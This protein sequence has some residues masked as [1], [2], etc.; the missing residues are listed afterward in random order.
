M[1]TDITLITSL[2]HTVEFLPDYLAFAQKLLSNATSANLQLQLVI[3]ANDATTE[4]QTLLT[5]F[6]SQHDNVDI[7]FVPRETLYASW[8]RGVT[9]AKGQL[10]GF[11]N[12]DDVRFVEA[13]IAAND[14]SY[15]H[16]NLIYFPFYEEERRSLWRI[17]LNLNRLT[18]APTYD[19]E[20]FKRKM[21]IGPFFLFTRT[22][23]EQVGKFDERFRISGDYDWC[24]RAMQHTEFCRCDVPAGTFINHGKNLSAG[25]HPL[26]TVEENIVYMKHNLLEQI[27]P[28]QPDLMQ[29]ALEAWDEIQLPTQV[30]SALLGVDAHENWTKYERQIHDARQKR[31]RSELI[32]TLPRWLIERTGLRPA[33]YRLG[34]VKTSPT[35]THV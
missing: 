17:P 6:I 16:C 31:R 32:R 26:Q 13:L 12:V 9:L 1:T 11:W 22:L 34:I 33:L 28:A 14:N 18:P 35:R 5:S 8:N 19:K 29:T 4:E 21:R 2:Y 23:Y 3:V 10:I 24:I 15:R 27:T 7:A 30:K 20:R 25:V